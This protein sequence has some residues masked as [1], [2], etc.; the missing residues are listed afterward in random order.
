M[1]CHWAISAFKISEFLKMVSKV[2][3]VLTVKTLET[4]AWSD[5][6]CP[7][8]GLFTI[9]VIPTDAR[10]VLSPIPESWRMV[11]VPK[12]PAESTIS[13]VAVTV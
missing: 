5:I 1:L 10:A 8:E 4:R 3:V 2:S 11:G 12:D 7:T 9:A 6:F 13:F